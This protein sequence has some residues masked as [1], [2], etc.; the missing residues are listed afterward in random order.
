MCTVKYGRVNLIYK[1]AVAAIS[2]IISGKNIYQGALDADLSSQMNNIVNVL[3]DSLNS[4]HAKFLNG[5]FFFFLDFYV[6]LMN[7]YCIVYADHRETIQ[8][9]Y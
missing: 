5:L 6:W 4:N 2:I 1:L 9:Q 7:V 8:V 3:A